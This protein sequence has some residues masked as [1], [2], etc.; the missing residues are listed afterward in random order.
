MNRFEER[1]EEGF[2]RFAE[3][4]TPSSTAFETFRTRIAEEADQPE[5]EI[6]MLQKNE[7]LTAR[8]GV[9]WPQLAAAAAVIVI[10]A[11]AAIIF[12]NRGDETVIIDQPDVPTTVLEDATPEQTESVNTGAVGI[13]TSF[14]EARN[15]YDAAA[16]TALIAP[17]AT[18]FDQ[19]FTV[20]SA[21]DYLDAGDVDW[22]ASADFERVTGNMFTDVSCEELEPGQVSCQYSWEN[23]WTRALDVAPASR[24]GIEHQPFDFDDLIVVYD[25]ADGQIQ[26]VQNGFRVPTGSEPHNVFTEMQDWLRVNHFDDNFL[27]IINVVGVPQRTAEL[28]PL[29]ETYTREFVAHYTA[30]VE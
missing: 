6:I 9:E 18:M 23:D 29:W 21:F 27:A 12:V 19:H 8:Q 24:M 10:A 5:V 28:I 2:D 16:T 11:L 4:A 17:D 7:D 30:P 26:S 14:L 20:A 22:V 1:I 25:I 3:Q 15:A 13:A